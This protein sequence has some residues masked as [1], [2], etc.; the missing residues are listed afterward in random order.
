MTADKFKLSVEESSKSFSEKQLLAVV[1]VMSGE[2]D[3]F[4]F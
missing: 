2:W 3:I 1:Q 4:L